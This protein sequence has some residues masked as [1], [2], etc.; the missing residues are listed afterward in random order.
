MSLPEPVDSIIRN[1]LA[2]E[3][4]DVTYRESLNFDERVGREFPDVLV[5]HYTALPL[6]ESLSHLVRAAT[7]VSTHFVIGRDGELFQLVSAARRAWHAGASLFAGEPDVNSRSLG[8][9]L[10]FVPDQDDGYPQ[11]QVEVLTTMCR[12]LCRM[13]PIRSDGIVGHQHVAMPRGRKQDP[14]RWL[15]WNFLY[16]E[17]GMGEPPP[18][19][20]SPVLF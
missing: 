18:F 7:R 13:F 20:T 15:D 19:L 9:D 3:S 14:G 12:V 5:I 11:H 10:V 6:E 4:L 8:I 16:R 2:A 1:K 17:S